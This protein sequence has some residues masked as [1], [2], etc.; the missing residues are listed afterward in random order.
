MHISRLRHCYSPEEK[1]RNTSMTTT[2]QSQRA[3][4]TQSLPARIRTIEQEMQQDFLEREDVIRAALV[5]FIAR[6]CMVLLGAPGTAKSEL[7]TTLASRFSLSYFVY[8]MT[9]FTTPDEI[10]GPVSVE[11]LKLGTF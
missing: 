7:I 6:S 5:N 1:E 8:L 4:T 2:E 10:F 3:S 11:G 9:R